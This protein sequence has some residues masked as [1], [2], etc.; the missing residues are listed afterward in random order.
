M[1]REVSRSARDLAEAV[2]INV[3]AAKSDVE[4]KIAPLA[5]ELDIK[6]TEAALRFKGAAAELLGK[7]DRWAV[8]SAAPPKVEQHQLHVGQPVLTEHDDANHPDGLA[9]ASAVISG[10]SLIAYGGLKRDGLSSGLWH[11]DL[12]SGAWRL[13][14]TRGSEPKPRAAHSAVL[15]VSGMYIYA[16]YGTPDHNG[17]TLLGDVHRLDLYEGRWQPVDTLGQPPCSR[18][19]HVA[20]LVGDA[21][22]IFGG[23]ATSEGYAPPKRS[24]EAPAVQACIENESDTSSAVVDVSGF[25][26]V[27]DMHVLPLKSHGGEWRRV[28]PSGSVPCERS[29]AC[30]T[31]LGGRVYLFGGCNDARCELDDLWEFRTKTA[32]WCRLPTVSESAMNPQCESPGPRALSGAALVAIPQRNSLLL[33]GGSTKTNYYGDLF[34]YQLPSRKDR[35]AHSSSGE[36]KRTQ[37]RSLGRGVAYVDNH[38][39]HISGW[40]RIEM[41]GVPPPRRANH[42]MLSHNG[43]LIIFGGFDG[44][45]FLGDVHAAVLSSTSNM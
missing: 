45:S 33:F 31:V 9:C 40:S 41:A 21:M 24:K 35:R 20:A 8:L 26:I 25:R 23:E 15:H 6:A 5:S 13:V 43:R 30:S 36:G 22:Y 39:K 1:L 27:N 38:H 44:S 12:S 29:G 17:D 14:T 7:G 28:Q 16:G 32:T 18:C 42:A 37:H 11:C 19:S 4:N 2:K 34:S 3:E 10:S